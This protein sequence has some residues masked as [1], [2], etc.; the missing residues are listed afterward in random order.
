[1]GRNLLH[2]YYELVFVSMYVQTWNQHAIIS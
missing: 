2:Y 1:M